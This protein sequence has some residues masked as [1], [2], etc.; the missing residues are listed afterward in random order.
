MRYVFKWLIWSLRGSIQKNNFPTN[1]FK[2]DGNKF[3]G[4][5]KSKHIDTVKKE[6]E[7]PTCTHCQKKGHDESKCWRLHMELNLEK[8]QNNKYKKTNAA[9]I[10]HDL[11]SDSGDETKV[12]STSI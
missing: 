8:F 2:P 9:A 5:G 10:Q 6:G 11:G 7:K 12:V 3:K 1:L 4:K